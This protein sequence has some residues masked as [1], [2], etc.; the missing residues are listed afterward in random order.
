MNL[1][2]V[3]SGKTHL[4]HGGRGHIL[5]NSKIVGH[6]SAAATLTCRNCIKQEAKSAGRAVPKAGKGRKRK[7]R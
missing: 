6:P 7:T 4:P 1:I 2:R 3:E 5:C